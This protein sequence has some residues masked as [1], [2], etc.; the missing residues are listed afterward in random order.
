MINGIWSVKPIGVVIFGS[1][2]A[3]LGVPYPHWKEM[4]IAAHVEHRVVI[5]DDPMRLQQRLDIAVSAGEHHLHPACLQ[6]HLE[7]EKA[8][9]R[10]CG[11]DAHLQNRDRLQ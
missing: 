10:R 4:T 11:I 2:L 9:P 3:T 5:C 8:R 6:D 7:H 1:K